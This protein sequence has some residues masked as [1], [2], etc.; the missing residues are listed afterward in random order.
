MQIK[1]GGERGIRTLG[2]LLTYTRFPG[3]L[4]Q[5]LGHLSIKKVIIVYQPWIVKIFMLVQ[6]W[7][8]LVIVH[9]KKLAD[10]N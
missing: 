10:G 9:G 7:E 4:L 3:V 1:S 8:N 5:P 2:T 6:V